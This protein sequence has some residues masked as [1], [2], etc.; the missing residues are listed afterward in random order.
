MSHP[1]GLRTQQPDH[2]AR[3]TP[4]TLPACFPSAST[5][6]ELQADQRVSGT[7]VH[8]CCPASSEQGR[9][10]CS[11]HKAQHSANGWL[12]DPPHTTVTASNPCTHI[13][14]DVN[15]NSNNMLI[16]PETHGKGS[17]DWDRHTDQQGRAAQGICAPATSSGL[18]LYLPTI[19]SRALSSA[20]LCC[21]AAGSACM[22]ARV[23][24]Q[25]SKQAQAW[26]RLEQRY[27]EQHALASNPTGAVNAFTT[28]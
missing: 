9:S 17:T 19:V 6:S 10:I 27:Q 21:P 12:N 14:A 1:A 4:T 2:D 28:A 22:Q 18:I 26:S 3:G 5:S 8:S 25:C 20:A 11:R 16:G 24:V 23:W 7:A 13:S 15:N